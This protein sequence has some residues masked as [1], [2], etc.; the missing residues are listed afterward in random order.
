MKACVEVE[1]RL[2]T[3]LTSDLDGGEF[4]VH[5]TVYR[6]KFICNKTN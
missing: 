1:L 6:N 2:H 3:F 4:Y 5:V